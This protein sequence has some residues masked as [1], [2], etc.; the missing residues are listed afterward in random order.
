MI[1]TPTPHESR[2][3]ASS[4]AGQTPYS[5]WMQT[6]ALHSLQRTVSDHPGEH[7]WITHVQVSELYWMLIIK[8]IQTAQMYLRADNLPQAH[9]TLLRVVAHH[10]PLLAI[11][12]SIDWMTPTD[13][14]AILS[15][16]VATY[17]QDTALQGWTYRQMVYLLGIK[18]PQHLDHFKPQPERWAQLAR[19]LSE[20]SLYDDV[21]AYLGRIGMAVPKSL[22]ERDLSA[23]Y[24]PSKEVEQVWRDI[25]AAPVGSDGLQQLGETLADIA[26]G[27]SHW[28]HRH[29]MATRRTFGARPAYFGT[30]GVAWLMPTMAEI[31]FPEL[32][33]ARTFIGDPSAVCPHMSQP[34]I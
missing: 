7:A 22:L 11:W 33:S 26:E 8:E 31:P 34:R 4:T 5:A 16:A 3:P 28:K 30:E 32:W 23:P 17:G 6:D 1:D 19:T 29:L 18:Q 15:R 2:A 9:R 12:R 10:E 20:P 14:L 13:L 24:S 27:F 21:L 25:Y